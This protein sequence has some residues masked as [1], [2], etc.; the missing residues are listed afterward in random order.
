[1]S[2][3]RGPTIAL[4][5][6]KGGVGKTTVALGLASSAAHH[7]LRVLVVDLDPQ[8]NASTGLGVWETELTVDV[9]LAADQPG[10]LRKVICPSTWEIPGGPAP[11]VAASSPLLAQ[12]E[13]QLATDPIGAQDR[14]QLAMEGLEYDLVLVDCPP[15]LGL[16]TV[17]G[18]FAAEQA[19]VVTEPS[20]WALD[21]VQQI[22]RTVTRVGARR[23]GAL[24]LAGIAVNRL[25]RT[26]DSRYWYNQLAEQY[27]E[28]ML[29]PIHLRAAVPEAA[30]QSLPIHALGSRPGAREAAAEFDDLLR[31][32]L[33]R[34]PA[35]E[36][37]DAGAGGTGGISGAGLQSVVVD[38]S[39][40]DPGAGGTGG[41]SGA[42]VP[43]SAGA[44]S[45]PG[46]ACPGADPA[47]AAAQNGEVAT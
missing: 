29:P 36:M 46:E 31:C 10:V 40:V 22:V 19:L 38:R 17:N 47:G 13:P 25:G 23:G 28:L 6:Q 11:D 21:G 9:A 15:S 44:W 5:N 32:V 39:P 18:L 45:A 8:A 33:G 34:E 42:G 7:G 30:A 35:D 14:L 37:L 27:T 12:R 1:M 20:A 26:R 2:A 41:I 3:T 16:L 4:V 24:A 43:G